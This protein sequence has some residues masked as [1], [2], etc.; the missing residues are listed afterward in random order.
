MHI[1]RMTNGSNPCARPLPPYRQPASVGLLILSATPAS[2]A[3]SPTAACTAIIGPT[4]SASASALTQ[5]IQ[6]SSTKIQ[7]TS[8]SIRTRSQGITK[9]RTDFTLY[10]RINSGGTIY[11]GY[12]AKKGAHTV[13]DLW[14]P[15]FSKLSTLKKGKNRVVIDG[16][17]DLNSH[18]YASQCAKSVSF[19][20]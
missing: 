3:A 17:F 20:F 6:P 7:P 15:S 9:T 10:V 11:N 4:K 12:V 16:W 2:A 5:Y 18:A 8:Y 1:T 19:A 13:N 14:G